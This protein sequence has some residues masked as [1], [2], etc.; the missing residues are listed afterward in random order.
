MK[1]P[2]MK[3]QAGC[4]GWEDGCCGWE[5]GCCCAPAC[6]NIGD[7]VKDDNGPDTTRKTERETITAIDITRVRLRI[8]IL[9]VLLLLLS[10]LLMSFIFY[11]TPATPLVQ[12]Y[13][14][15]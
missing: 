4:C 9:L 11:Y 12:H 5:D 8:V 7:N 10:L 1:S 14:T 3:A 13:T 6:F 15:V 2:S